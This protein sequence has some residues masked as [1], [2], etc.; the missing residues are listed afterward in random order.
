MEDGEREDV[1]L[2]RRDVVFVSNSC[3]T[4]RGLVTGSRRQVGFFPKVLHRP[5]VNKERYS[6]SIVQ[7]LGKVVFNRKARRDY[8]EPSKRIGLYQPSQSTLPFGSSPHHCIFKLHS[9][10]PTFWKQTVIQEVELA[11][12]ITLNDIWNTLPARSSAPTEIPRT[13]QPQIS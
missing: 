13:H 8:S 11:A 7:S 10:G 12:S 1:S 9:G 6:T 5:I 3:L 4:S 2:S